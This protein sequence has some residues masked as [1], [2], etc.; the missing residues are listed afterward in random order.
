MR[1]REGAALAARVRDVGEVDGDGVRARAIEAVAKGHCWDAAD[2]KRAMK[3]Q[4]DGWLA[5]MVGVIEHALREE[6]ARASAPPS[7]LPVSASD[8]AR[9][10]AAWW[11][12]RFLSAP[13][14]EQEVF[15]AAHSALMYGLDGNAEQ[16][17]EA[18]QE[19]W[20][21]LMTEKA[22]PSPPEVLATAEATVRS[23]NVLDG[24]VDLESDVPT[25]SGCWPGQRVNVAIL[26]QGSD[27]A[28]ATDAIGK[29][30]AL[31]DEADKAHTPV[32]SVDALR[33]ILGK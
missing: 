15:I 23:I 29:V 4:P 6:R 20:R 21:L 28:R 5:R 9:E 31:L 14:S 30:K 2:M 27:G 22:P 26:T 11:P 12:E 8:A 17:V 33:A 25:W 16:A 13:L 32:V 10:P 1:G 24:R 7:P 18:L 19:A 3:V